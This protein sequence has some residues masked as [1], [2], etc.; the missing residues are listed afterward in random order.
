MIDKATIVAQGE[1]LLLKVSDDNGA[2]YFTLVCL[3]KQGMEKTRNINKTNTQC[4]QQIGKGTI[5]RGIPVEGVI[6]TSI[7]DEAGGYASYKKMNEW[8]ENFTPLIVDQRHPVNDGANFANKGPA[9]LTDLKLDAPVDNLVTW[10]A[11]LTGF[12]AWVIA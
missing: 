9:Y 1:D 4:G 5:D 12:G 7:V 10:S 6:D 8:F 11:T 3:V 2:N